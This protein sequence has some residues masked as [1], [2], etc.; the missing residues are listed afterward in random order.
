MIAPKAVLIAAGIFLV[1]VL[2]FRYVSLG[3][4]VAVSLF[5]SLVWQLHQYGNTWPALAMMSLT[6]LLIVLKHSSN[7]SRLLA[8]TENRLGSKRA[9]NDNVKTTRSG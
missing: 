2:V 9:H 1:V 6:A 5:P 4:V 7:I 3:S 8:G